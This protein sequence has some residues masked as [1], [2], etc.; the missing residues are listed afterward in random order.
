MSINCTHT[1]DRIVDDVSILGNV[2]PLS[3]MS[4]FPVLSTHVI[5]ELHSVLAEMLGSATSIV[6]V[7][8]M[9][10]MR[11]DYDSHSSR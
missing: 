5:S 6:V 8:V 3:D 7:E 2:F 1:F 11:V 4:H 10:K 9:S